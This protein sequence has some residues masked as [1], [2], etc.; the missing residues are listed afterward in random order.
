MDIKFNPSKI[1][2]TMVITVA[3][4]TVAHLMGMFSTFA[5]GHDSMHGLI[6]LV[7]LEGENNI[8]AFYSSSAILFCAFILTIIAAASKQRNEPHRHWAGLAFIFFF[9][10]ADEMIQ[11]HEKL[12]GLRKVLHL[13]G[14]LYHAWV[15]PYLIAAAVVAFSYRKF[16]FSLRPQTRRLI[17]LGGIIYVTGAAGFEM[18]GGWYVEHHG[19][20]LTAALMA[21]VEEV[22]E[23]SGIV[24][25]ANTLLHYLHD[26]FSLGQGERAAV[27]GVKED[28]VLQSV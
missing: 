17:I 19:W 26:N 24:I 16:I 4:I 13:S 23:M 2:R 14:I 3:L 15:L 7:D 6:D 11:I 8:P 20:N 12:I 28:V 9:L 18:I 10:S 22:M 25:F 21:T 1:T 27:K 5:L